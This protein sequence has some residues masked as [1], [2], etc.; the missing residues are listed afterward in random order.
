MLSINTNVL[1]H[2]I[3][4]DDAAQVRAAEE[5][6]SKGAWISHLNLAETMWVLDSVKPSGADSPR[7]GRRERSPHSV[8]PICKGGFFRLPGAGNCHKGR[9]HPDRHV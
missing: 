4:P 3:A 2:L 8:P 1:V 9:T 6:V 5:I 7:R